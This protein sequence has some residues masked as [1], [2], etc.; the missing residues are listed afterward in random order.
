[1]GSESILD[2][3]IAVLLRGLVPF[4]RLSYPEALY[5]AEQQASAFLKLVQVHEPPVPIEQ[6]VVETGLAA[7][8]REDPTLSRPGRSWLD[9]AMGNWIIS[10]HPESS[11]GDRAYVIAHEVKHILD[12]GFGPTLYQPVDVMTSL[13]RAEHGANAFATFLLMPQP[14]IERAWKQG[15]RNVETLAD[16]FGVVATRM[17]LRL[18]ALALPENAEQAALD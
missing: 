8:I 14:W 12:E 9:Q 2:R 13:E 16:S 18:E 6:L 1:M 7:E 3:H 10:L 15:C 5:Y 11:M 17:S 4:R